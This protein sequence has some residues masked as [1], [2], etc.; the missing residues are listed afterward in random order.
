MPIPVRRIARVVIRGEWITVADGTFE[1]EELEFT[2]DDGIPLHDP[3]DIWAYRF[4]TD[5]ADEY[6]GPLSAI[7]LIKLKELAEPVAPPGRRA[8]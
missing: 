3:T 5:K 8:L 2:D 1:V 4:V 6:Y 7:E